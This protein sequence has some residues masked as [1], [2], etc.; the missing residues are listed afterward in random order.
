[1]SCG[2]CGAGIFLDYSEAVINDT[3]IDGNEAA[4]G[5]GIFIM[6]SKVVI[7]RG[8]IRNNSAQ[9]A[10]DIKGCGGAIWSCGNQL[11]LNGTMIEDN[12][13][14]NYGGAILSTGLPTNKGKVIL[15][16]DTVVAGNTAAKGAAIYN[17]GN[18]E[19]ELQGGT[20]LA[21]N[22]ATYGGPIYNEPGGTVTYHI[23]ATRGEKIQDAIDSAPSGSLI[24][25]ASGRYPENLHI[26]QSLNI[27]GSSGTVIDGRA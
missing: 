20:Q 24:L 10:G 27:S 11:V 2:G 21:N 22:Q 16:E 9:T 7:N 14:D 3:V 6:G 17:R 4:L 19:V 13:A 5:G 25:V 15:D 23:D 18:S 8:A 12:C 1:M 26:D